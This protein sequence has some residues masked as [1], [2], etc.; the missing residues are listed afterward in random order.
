MLGEHGT[1]VRMSQM[2]D[3]LE[4][5]KVAVNWDKTAHFEKLVGQATEEIHGSAKSMR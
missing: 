3:E 1:A 4:K 5:R 2:R